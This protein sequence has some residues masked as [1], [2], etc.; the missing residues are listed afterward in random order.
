MAVNRFIH[1]CSAAAISRL[2]TA[3]PTGTPV[4]RSASPRGLG[5]EAEAAAADPAP[6][7]ELGV[8]PAAGDVADL[9]GAGA[10][11][12]PEAESFL[13]QP[14]SADRATARTASHRA[15]W[16]GLMAGRAVGR[17]VV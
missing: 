14:V 6:G 1:A 15:V 5:A 2:V 4:S 11:S 17:D 16:A 13:P 8:A 12:G 7:A 10:A 9:A 3:A